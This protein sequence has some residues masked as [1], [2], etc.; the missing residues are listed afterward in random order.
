MESWRFGRMV[1]WSF[2]YTPFLN[3]YPEDP[4]KKA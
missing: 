2:P 1:N 4:A 3:A